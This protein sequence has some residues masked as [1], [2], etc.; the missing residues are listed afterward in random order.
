MF[1][2]TP[3]QYF[4]YRA[5]NEYGI[6]ALSNNEIYFA[7]PSELNDP[8]D[9]RIPYDWGFESNEHIKRYF[10]ISGLKSEFIKENHINEMNY[11]H[12][13]NDAI[14]RQKLVDFLTIKILDTSDKYGIYS[15]SKVHD[16]IIMLI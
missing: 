13:F 1:Q 10:E 4:K 8:F 6:S 2:D 3:K 15:V 7:A 5:V 11:Y 9:C 16:S 12:L 14:Q